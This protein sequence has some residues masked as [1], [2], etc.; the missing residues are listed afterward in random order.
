M[1]SIHQMCR[2]T[3]WY[4][5]PVS[6]AQDPA[7]GLAGP[8][9]PTAGSEPATKGERTR[10]RLLDLA[11]ARFGAR[12]YRATSVSEIARAAGLT[13][14][15]AYAYF[16]SKE[17]LF[18]AAVDADAAALVEE[19]EQQASDVPVGQLVPMLVMCFLTG[20]EHHP[21]TRRVVGGQEPDALSRLVNLPALGRLTGDIADSVR[22][23]QARGEVRDDIDADLFASGAESIIVS[24]VMSVTQVGGS[25]EARRQL[26]VL[27]I[28]DAVLRPPPG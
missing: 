22:S 27:S 21:L 17:A 6:L 24:L 25:T 4:R 12:G 15:A 8:G 11:I 2:Q 13:Q 7:G 26:G 18:D 9:D 5:G 14:A 19:A 28:F 23:A 1:S 20:L 3:T 10:Q 16:P